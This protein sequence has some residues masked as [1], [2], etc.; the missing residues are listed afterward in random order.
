MSSFRS[1]F[2]F[3][4]GSLSLI[5]F[6]VLQ[7]VLISLS[8]L[9][10]PS[11]ITGVVWKRPCA[12]HKKITTRDG[13]EIDYW[14]V[15]GRINGE[16]LKDEDVAEAKVMV[17]ANGLGCDGTMMSFAPLMERMEERGESWIFL[18]WVYRGLFE[19]DDPLRPRRLAIPEHAEDLKEILDREK[20]KQIDLLVGHSMGVQVSLEMSV[21]YPEAVEKMLLLNG[22]HGHVFH[23]GFQPL[24]R[25][26]GMHDLVSAFTYFLMQKKN[27]FYSKIF[28]G[29]F[30]LMIPFVKFY[31][32]VFESNYTAKKFG[33]GFNETFLRSYILGILHSTKHF[34]NYLRLFRE[35]D[36]HSVHHLLHEIK[37]PTLIISGALDP[38]LPAYCSYEMAAA[39]EN[40]IHHCITF[41][42]HASLLE[43][44][45]IVLGHVDDF[46]TK[47]RF[48]RVNSVVFE[49]S[50]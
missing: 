28:V 49:K 2:Y 50:K 9:F 42:S 12:V 15:R 17:F 1:L 34:T 47:R 41:S 16:Q 36:A 18:T 43:A 48:V 25:L 40:S 3:L 20:I 31:N 13:L 7:R 27:E 37:H 44:P 19:S 39:M 21:L 14:V 38:C 22:S 29:S 6:R 26:P 5:L 24:F 30:W 8:G 32:F 23:S 46:L 35:L 11:P 33:A 10:V 4:I 45:E